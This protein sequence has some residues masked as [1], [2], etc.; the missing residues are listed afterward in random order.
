MAGQNE[1]GGGFGPNAVQ[2]PI[3]SGGSIYKRFH[4]DMSDH[5]A[6]GADHGNSQLTGGFDQPFI[7][8]Q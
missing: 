7:G 5:R 1:M 6:V 4:I 8:S 2:F 3:T